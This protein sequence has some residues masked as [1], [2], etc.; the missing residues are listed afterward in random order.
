MNKEPLS[1]TEIT[2]NMKYWTNPKYWDRY[3]FANGVHPDQRL[4]TAA[5]DQGLH[6]LP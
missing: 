3:A 4:Q 2:L 1:T 5:S 6:Y